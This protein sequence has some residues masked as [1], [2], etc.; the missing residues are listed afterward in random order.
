VATSAQVPLYLEH[1]PTVTLG[2]PDTSSGLL[3]IV[4]RRRSHRGYAA[5]PLPLAALRDC[6]YAGLAIT[7]FAESG[8]PGEELLPLTT[9]PSG[10]ARNPF[11]GYVVARHVEGLEPGVYHYA[12][13]SG[14]LARVGQDPPPPLSRLLGG[15]E[16]FDGAGALIVLVAHFERTGWKHP[17]PTGSRV[18]LIEAGHIAQNV[19]LCATAHGLAATPTCAVSD[20]TLEALLG[21]DRLKHAV[22][23]T[24][25]LGA[26]DP[27]PSSADIQTIHANPRLG[28]SR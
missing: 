5:S 28:R 11:E 1:E 10:G 27:R 14:S 4:S 24:V 21:L 25:A 26:R 8:I 12:G 17:H 18:I 3:E 19:L 15:Q 22:I 20:Q 16:W 7:G 23:H 2:P 9:T 13:V 6:L